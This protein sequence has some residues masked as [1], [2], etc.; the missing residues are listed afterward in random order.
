MIFNLLAS[1]IS[2]ERVTIGSAQHVVPIC[3]ALLCCVVLIRV[4]NRKFNQQ[5]KEK[6][7]QWLGAFVSLTV[8]VF[9]GYYMSLGT[10]NFSEDLPLFLC[11]FLALIIPVFTHFR[12]YW[13]YE[14]LLFWI[15]AGT[16]QGVITPDIAEGFPSFDYFR[17]WIVHLGLLI[18]IFYAT[19][20]LKMRPQFKSVFKSFLALQVYAIVLMGVNYLL[21]ANYSYLNR[22]P[23]SA[24]ALD[25][26]GDWP[27]Y[28]LV[29][30]AIL[31]PFF[32]LIYLLFY[33]T[34]K[35]AFL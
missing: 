8:L 27:Y 24:S 35:K 25:Y 9:H 7:F 29:M 18:I 1:S 33:L 11:S 5:Q 16:S 19:L 20:V 31:I 2:L 12:K 21:D 4:S 32:L 10:Y 34:R 26:L 15:I 14:I 28:L 22:K 13:M 23:E 6:T 3:I 17:Y 30:E